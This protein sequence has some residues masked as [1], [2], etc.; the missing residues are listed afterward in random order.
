MIL[1]PR[2]DL[3]FDRDS[4]AAYLPTMIALMVF[5]ATLAL[6]AVLVLQNLITRWDRDIQGTLTVQVLPVD[7]DNKSVATAKRVDRAVRLLEDTPGVAT[8]RVLT[9][10]E[11]SRLI[12]PW[13]GD[14]TLIAD[15]PLPRLIDV[16]L[17]PDKPADL[18]KLAE[19]LKKA[20]PGASVDDH[21]VWLARI[22]RLAE[23]LKMLSRA[24]MA[25]VTLA[26]AFAVIHATRSAL[27]I[28]R[29][30]IEILHL[31]GAHDGY[32]ARQYALRALA[33]GLEGAVIGFACAVPVLWGLGRMAKNIEGGLL[34]EV[35][36]STQHWMGLAVIPLAAALV[37]MIAA[38]LTVMRTLHRM[39]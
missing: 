38:F 11:L 4:G 25:L 12:E 5:L 21:R 29:R 6:A 37:A 20:I 28:H 32:V 27:E 8:V 23:G 9:G 34:A 10:E 30:S 16:S 2:S 24:V 17:D 39:I 15:L 36:L 26:A 35:G 3:P 33:F 13:L 1:K 31:V 22:V 7:G 18:D 14:V 19:A